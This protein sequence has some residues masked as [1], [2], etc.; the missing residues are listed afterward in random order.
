MSTGDVVI[1]GGGA[2]AITRRSAPP[3]S[4][5]RWPASRGASP[6]FAV[7]ERSLR[8]PTATARKAAMTSPQAL[9]GSWLERSR[10]KCLDAKTASRQRE[11]AQL[12]ERQKSRMASQAAFSEPS[13]S[14]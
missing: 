10:R 1:I 5:S 3:S 13:S 7:S 8:E 6:W 4:A 11:N 12:T 14:A 9:I 2:G